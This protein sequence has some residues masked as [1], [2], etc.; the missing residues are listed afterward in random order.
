MWQETQ[1]KNSY[2]QSARFSNSLVM[3]AV[4]VPVVLILWLLSNYRKNQTTLGASSH[5][6]Y[7]HSKIKKKSKIGTFADEKQTLWGR[8]SFASRQ[9]LLLLRHFSFLFE[10]AVDGGWL[11]T[12]RNF[13]RRKTHRLFI[14]F[15][16]C[17][18]C[19]FHANYAYLLFPYSSDVNNSLL[20]T[21]SHSFYNVVVDLEFL[22]IFRN[23]Q[24]GANS[25]S[26]D[27]QIWI[28]RLLG[29]DWQA[30]HTYKLC[31]VA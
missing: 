27:E 14:T 30:I 28:V 7:H 17:R 11:F 19:C 26:N 12:G 20:I 3:H 29:S 5:R 18:C 4:S 24:L 8:V 31:I 10:L 16:L 6:S 9:V 22:T 23:D 15:L 21:V 2:F 13:I 1:N 25:K